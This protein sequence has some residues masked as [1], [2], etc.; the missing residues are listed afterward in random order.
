MNVC[1]NIYICHNTMRVIY[2]CQSF[3][4]FHG[5]PKKWKICDSLLDLDIC[6][7]NQDDVIKW[8]HSP[9]YWS[10]VRGIHWLPVNYLRKGR[11]RG[12]LMFS[13]ICVWTNGWAN[14]QDSGGLR[15]IVLIM[16]PPP[17]ARDSSIR[18]SRYTLQIKISAVSVFLE[19]NHHSVITHIITLDKK[20]T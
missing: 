10:F 6:V 5:A 4:L 16:T 8:K 15:A 12:D 1:V 19:A 13:L 9:H 17:H 14:H 18:R 11:W 3:G 7:W 20:D 2:S